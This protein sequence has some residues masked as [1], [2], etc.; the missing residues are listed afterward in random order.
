MTV[1]HYVNTVGHI[2]NFSFNPN[3]SHLIRSKNLYC[4]NFKGSQDNSSH[5]IVK[6]Y[7][8]SVTL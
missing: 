8:F 1:L 2:I 6:N 5:Y 3:D 7:R 4:T